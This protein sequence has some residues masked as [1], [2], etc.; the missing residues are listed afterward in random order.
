MSS[1]KEIYDTIVIGAGISGVT[2]AGHLNRNGANVLVLE[3]SSRIGGR[4]YT[5][6]SSGSVHYELGCSW[7][8]RPPGA[9]LLVDVAKENNITVADD[10]GNI[11]LVDDNGPCANASLLGDFQ[12]YA[13]SLIEDPSKCDI[14]LKSAIDQYFGQKSPSS[15]ELDLLR[16]LQLGKGLDWSTLSLRMALG[17][18]G[19]QPDLLVVDG[20]DKIVQSVGADQ[21]QRSGKILLN[22]LVTKVDESGDLVAVN[23]QD[24][25]HFLC[26]YVICTVPIGALKTGRVQFLPRLNPEVAK[27]VD[28]MSP[29]HVAKVYF[30]FKD[31]FWDNN[32]DRFL[33]VGASGPFVL[34]NRNKFS[35]G[36]NP[37]IFA[38]M[39][40]AH[41]HKVESA[42]ET[43]FETLLPALEAIRTDKSKPVPRPTTVTVSRWT[44]DPNFG[45]SYSTFTFDAPQ[46]RQE[47]VDQLERPKESK[48]KF[49]GEH[50]TMDGATFAHGA[51]NS[52][53][54][55]ANAVLSMLRL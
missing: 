51:Y 16:L 45:G 34:P 29:A 39:G 6:R 32:V 44:V 1:D 18:V 24:G 55:E 30:E 37:T 13:R 54:R 10:N 49:A 7:F 14:S 25:R 42:P 11:C 26:K 36:G 17:P 46:T 27:A 53:L 5:D 19:S 2:A 20:F 43:A 50:T 15:Q 41:A 47:C 12:A 52:G 28:S 23:T 31:L 4:A 9:N 48:V 38:I 35:S 3:A 33:Y 40:A 8:H 22:S 21:L